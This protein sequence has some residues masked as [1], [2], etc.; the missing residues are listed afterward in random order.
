MTYKVQMEGT[1]NG[2]AFEVIGEG[3]G[4]PATNKLNICLVYLAF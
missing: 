3:Q 1:V 2:H 4:Q